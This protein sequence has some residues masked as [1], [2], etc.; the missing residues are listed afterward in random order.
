MP[1]LKA[2][3]EA[4]MPTMIGVLVSSM[5]VC[6]CRS[7]PLLLLSGIAR[8][9]GWWVPGSASISMCSNGPA[10]DSVL[11][12]DVFGLTSVDLGPHLRE[13]KSRICSIR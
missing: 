6:P 7:T 2:P 8:L 3:A 13:G 10:T 9:C 1:Q 12:F 11:W 4:P 5:C